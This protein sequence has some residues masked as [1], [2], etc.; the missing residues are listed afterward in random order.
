MLSDITHLLHSL[1]LAVVQGLTE[2]LPVS[3]SGHLVLFQHWLGSRQGDVFFDIVLHVGPLGSVIAVYRRE[4]KRLLR[5]DE[6]AL[7]YILSLAIGTLP[8]VLVGLLARHA[9]ESLFHEPRFAAGGLLLTAA[10]LFSTRMRTRQQEE[11]PEPWTP[12]PVAPARGIT[13][14]SSAACRRPGLGRGGPRG[15]WCA[16]R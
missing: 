10:L 6:A 14:R 8:A 13:R 4:L 11:L 2:F 5:C 15:A 1:A 7:R 12:R 16:G 9:V 3:S